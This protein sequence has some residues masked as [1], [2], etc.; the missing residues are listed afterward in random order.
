VTPR[1]GRALL[2]GTILHRAILAEA[3]SQE[4][5]RN[6]SGKRDQEGQ[7]QT[8]HGIHPQQRNCRGRLNDGKKDRV[9]EAPARPGSLLFPCL[10]RRPLNPGA[11]PNGYS[12]SPKHADHQELSAARS[13]TVPDRYDC[14]TRKKESA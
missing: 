6:A 12:K 1:C 3:P 9:F 10:Y 2:A 13:E 5:R 8:R 7:C 4:E 11:K 14:S